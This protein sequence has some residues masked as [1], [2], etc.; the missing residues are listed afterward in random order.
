M[1]GLI[2]SIQIFQVSCRIN[3]AELTEKNHEVICIKYVMYCTF[4]PLE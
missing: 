2:L 4:S 3:I 1:L